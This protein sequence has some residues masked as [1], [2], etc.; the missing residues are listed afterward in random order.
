[1][2]QATWDKIKAQ[3]NIDSALIRQLSDISYS[4]TR[5][6][7][8]QKR[9]LREGIV[10]LGT[11]PFDVDLPRTEITKEMITEYHKSQAGPLIDPI[12][13]TVRADKYNPST[14]AYD[15]TQAQSLPPLVNDP[16]LG[17]PATEADIQMYKDN[18]YQL[19][20]VDLPKANDDY[21]NLLIDLEVLKDVLNEG[22]FVTTSSGTSRRALSP[23]EKTTLE[24]EILT[25]GGEITLQE[26]YINQ[27][28]DDADEF[29]S[30]MK[31]AK[32]NIEDNKKVVIQHN[33]EIRDNVRLFKENLIA[34]NAT[35]VYLEQQP[36]ES[37]ADFLQRM[38]NVE[39][40]KFD[41]NIYQ[42]KG[43]FEQIIRLKN[44]LKEIIRSDG[45]IENITKSFKSEQIFVINKHFI[46]IKDKFLETY[47]FD[48]KNLTTS[49]IVEVITN[50]L[51]RILNPPLEYE[52]QND[53]SIVPASGETLPVATFAYTDDA[54]NT[55][56]TDFKFGTDTNSLYIENTA[57]N[58]HVFLKV[59]EKE[60]KLIFYSKT[61]NSEGSFIAVKQRGDPR[62]DTLKDIL[63]NYLNLDSI[64]NTEIFKGSKQFSD[65]YDTLINDYQ[66]IPL[67]GIKALR[68]TPTT[69]RC[70]WGVS[71]P[72]E[73]IPNHGQFGKLVILLNKLFYKNMLSL[74]HQSGHSI[75]G[76]PTIKVSDKFVEIIMGIYNDIN[77]AN[78]AK[79]LN[80]DEKNLLDSIL[81]M[82][83]LNKK[84]VTDT[85]KSLAGL[86][87]QFKI[88]EG[89][90]MAGNDNPEVLKELKDVLL[91]L[92]HLGAISLSG[93]K[94][95]LKQFE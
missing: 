90:I 36:N 29:N 8:E 46:Q 68:P 28:Q 48:N 85:G 89:Q 87:E 10:D 56:T 59:G 23:T 53:P 22:K 33:K 74:K 35:K 86:K 5:G 65:I 39:Q 42:E 20:K 7:R 51:E 45:L 55:V 66:L 81:F 30:K 44:N 64:A 61:L 32:Q 83:G 60:R 6:L 79:N 62:E 84:I 3:N 16:T 11:I 38:K 57:N 91:K 80:T 88:I 25:K 71:H 50:S 75:Q 12:T 26:T 69:V 78:L 58:R 52:I 31:S 47:G 24:A 14:F 93:I 18:I 2:K 13:G 4:S 73:T 21:K 70:G 49:D 17:T 54:G 27:I 77:V 92:N 67:T 19:L 1:M 94:K 9:S 15:M 37:D 43:H 41:L 34:N 76:F 82:A 40:E 95:Y 63:F 72:A